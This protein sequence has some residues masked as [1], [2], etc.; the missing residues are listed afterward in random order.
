MNKERQII[1]T[2]RL[3]EQILGLDHGLITS[4]IFNMI[5]I[6]IIGTF[7]SEEISEEIYKLADVVEETLDQELEIAKSW[8]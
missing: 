3:L 6:L 2:C 4:D 8:R 7:Y 1:D 5:S